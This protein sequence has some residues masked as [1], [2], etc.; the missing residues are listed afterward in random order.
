M[1][2]DQGNSSYYLQN[3]YLLIL[4]NLFLEDELN[5]WL[6]KLELLFELIFPSYFILYLENRINLEKKDEMHEE[7]EEPKTGKIDQTF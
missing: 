3:L 2:I 6:N 7:K 5:Y 1:L 4:F